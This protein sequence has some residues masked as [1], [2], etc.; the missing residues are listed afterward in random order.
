MGKV[1]EVEKGLTQEAAEPVGADLSEVR[2]L[3]TLSSRLTQLQRML[4]ISPRRSP[5]PTAKRTTSR[6]P[7]F[8]HFVLLR[9]LLHALMPSTRPR[10]AKKIAQKRLC[11]IEAEVD[12][13]AE[14]LL[15]FDHHE[16]A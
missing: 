9:L 12:D 11:G 1:R 10:Q 4:Q 14:G 16:I 8:R 3:M 13:H 6:R 7:R 15:C 5:V 2:M